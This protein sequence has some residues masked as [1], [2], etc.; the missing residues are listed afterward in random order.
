MNTPTLSDEKRAEHVVREWLRAHEFNV[1]LYNLKQ[2]TSN[3]SAMHNSHDELEEARKRLS[4]I[5]C[6]RHPEFAALL[7]ETP[8]LV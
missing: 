1:R 4:E 5:R 3:A 2:T 7:D 6:A 8:V